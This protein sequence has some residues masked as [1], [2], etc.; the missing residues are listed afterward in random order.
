MTIAEHFEERVGRAGSL[1]E[2]ELAHAANRV[3]YNQVW[4][5]ESFA[6]PVKEEETNGPP[7]LG[8]VDGSTSCKV[9]SLQMCSGKF[10][11]VLVANH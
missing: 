9:H 11:V 6:R 8:M 7:F 5:V 2:T 10:F 1:V 3:N 4:R